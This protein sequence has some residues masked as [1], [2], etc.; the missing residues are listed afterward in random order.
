MWYL[1]SNAVCKQTQAYRVAQAEVLEDEPGKTNYIFQPAKSDDL[2]SDRAAHLEVVRQVC[3]WIMQYL[4]RLLQTVTQP[5]TS[6]SAVATNLCCVYVNI[7]TTLLF[8][9]PC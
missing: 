6:L 5:A 2:L 8:I 4:Y 9:L 1:T 3:G 7:A